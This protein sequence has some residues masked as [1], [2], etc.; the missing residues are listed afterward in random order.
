MFDYLLIHKATEV[1]ETV[2]VNND[3]YIFFI[4]IWNRF[5]SG[6]TL[7]LRKDSIESKVFEF[8]Q[9]IKKI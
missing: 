6:I 1:I 2:G 5:L 8:I 7:L 4:R 9:T 3:L